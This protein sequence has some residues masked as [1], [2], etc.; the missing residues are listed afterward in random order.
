MTA[1]TSFGLL[2]ATAVAAAIVVGGCGGGSVVSNG[3]PEPPVL[4][5]WL[6]GADGT[7][8]DYSEIQGEEVRV[9]AE[10]PDTATSVQATIE[11]PPGEP[12]P[13]GGTIT[14]VQGPWT[15][16]ATWGRGFTVPPNATT[17]TVYDIRV[18]AETPDGPVQSDLIRLT[19]IHQMPPPPP[20]F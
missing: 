5:A 1:R 18:T 15:A 19:V 16:P 14:L 8:P 13:D 17:G 10:A 11:G 4:N 20:P 7:F 6:E 3:G 9:L 12:L 2:L